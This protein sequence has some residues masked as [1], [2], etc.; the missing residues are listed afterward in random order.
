[1]HVPEIRQDGLARVSIAIASFGTVTS[2]CGPAATMRSPATTTAAYETVDVL[3]QPHACHPLARVCPYDALQAATHFGQSAH[4]IPG[5]NGDQ[6]GHDVFIA[7][8]NCLEMTEFGIDCED[9]EQLLL[10]IQPQLFRVPQMRPATLCRSGATCLPWRFYFVLARM[11]NTDRPPEG[12]VCNL[13]GDPC[14]T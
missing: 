11:L 6:L 4:F 1:M 10:H 13:G 9:G 8:A 7:V 2:D 5:C 14:A 3:S 12:N